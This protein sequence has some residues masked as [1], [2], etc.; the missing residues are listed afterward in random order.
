MKISVLGPVGTFSHEAGLV[1]CKDAQFLF[2]DTIYD[3]FDALSSGRVDAAVVPLENSV[4]GS[5]GESL[6]ALLEFDL[7]VKRVVFLDVRHNLVGNA[8]KDIKRLYVH[9]L[10]HAQCRE[11][12]RRNFSG[13]EIVHT[14]SNAVSA[15]LVKEPF[16]GAIVPGVAA[17]I[18]GKKVIDEDVQDTRGQ[19]VTLFGVLGK[20]YGNKT[21][22]DRTFIVFDCVDRAGILYEILGLFA[23]AGVN[24]SK[25]ESRPNKRKMGEYI[26]YVE[27]YGHPQDEVVL[28]VIDELKGKVA[29]L[30]VLGAYP[31]EVSG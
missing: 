3:V 26:F 9:P 2:E 8:K 24:L 1:Y 25:I 15:T 20:G 22:N 19:N 21:G 4:S 28:R 6:D 16:D 10:A 18:Y 23:K 12:V 27:F 17:K 11:Y 7:N 29:F 5:V 31:R 13:V 14:S 30:K